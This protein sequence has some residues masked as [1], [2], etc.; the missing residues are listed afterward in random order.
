MTM[1]AG[2][3]HLRVDLRVRIVVHVPFGLL[4]RRLRRLE[5]VK[6]IFCHV[7]QPAG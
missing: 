3:A 4:F 6:E 1:G 2:G 7:R 5:I